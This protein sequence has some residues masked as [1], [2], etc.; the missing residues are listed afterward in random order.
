MYHGVVDCKHDAYMERNFHTVSEFRQH[1]VHLKRMRVVPIEQLAHGIETGRHLTAA[2]TFDDGFKNNLVAAEMLDSAGIPWSLFVSTQDVG[3]SSTIWTSLVGLLLLHGQAS[4]VDVLGHIWDLR[5]R[6]QR[7]ESFGSIR[8]IAK[9]LNRAQRLTFMDSLINNFPAEEDIRLVSEFPMFQMLNW[10]DLRDLSAAGVTVGS[11]GA[12]HELL[13]SDQPDEV[14]K[15]ELIRSRGDIVSELGR[16]CDYLA[17][18]N[19]DHSARSRSIV[20]DLA[21]TLAFTTED[22][23][24]S[25]SQDRLSLPRL[26]ARG[27]ELAFLR[28][29]LRGCSAG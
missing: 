22:G 29:L 12:H 14:V 28:S 24:V 1:L 15:S 2:I 27:D 3:T 6:H 8:R 11:H 10:N 19:G 23:A 21:Y 13:H 18:P 4:S 20:Q 16:A 7:L 17:Y 26:S 5:D 25:P 9:R